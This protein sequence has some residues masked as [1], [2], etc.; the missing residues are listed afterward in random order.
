MSRR[1][2]ITGL[3][4]INPLG[5]D[6]D[7]TWKNLLAGKSGISKI[8][9]FELDGLRCHIAG[10]VRDFNVTDYYIEPKVANKMDRHQQFAYASLIEAAKMARIPLR[11]PENHEQ[12]LPGFEGMEPAIEDI[13]RMG[14]FFGIGVGGISTFEQQAIMMDKRGPR[15]VTPF[16]IPKMIVNLTGGWIAQAT[17][18]RGVNSTYVTA[19]ASGGNALGEAFLAIKNDRADIMISG[20][21]EAGICKMAIA[22]FGNMHALS[23]NFNDTP[24][25]ASRPFDKDRDG[26][27]MGEGG[28]VLVLEEY[29]HAKKRGANILGEMVGYGITADAYHIT[30]PNPGAEGGVRATQDAIKDG[31]ITPDKVDYINAHGTS[32]TANDRMETKAIKEI[33][34]DSAKKISISSTKSMTGHLLG[35]AGAIEALVIAKACQDNKIPPTIN[36]DEPSEGFDLD[37]TPNKMKE[38]EINYAISNSFGFGGHNVVI[39]FKK[40]TG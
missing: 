22:G 28:A 6:V 5:K 40:Y 33:F 3:G 38:K 14:V 9:G 27:V 36:L 23:S 30:S 29:E 24:E 21:C 2:V 37:Y 20:G 39:M 11:H 17:N 15:R 25:K 10:H 26:F 13:Y 34:G 4:T 19:C 7:T 31:G 16:L 18:A 1:V 8:D 12:V 32:T 35:G